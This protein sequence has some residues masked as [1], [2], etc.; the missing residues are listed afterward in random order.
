LSDTSRDSGF[1]L[2]EV[3]IAVVLLGILSAALYGSYFGVLRARDRASSGMESRRELGATLD[4]IRREVSSAQFRQSDKRLRFVVEDRD[5]FGTPSS[6]LTLT[7]E[8]PT[9]GQNRK[10]SGIITVAYRITEKNKKRTLTRQERDL[11][12]EEELILAYPQMEQITAFLVECYDGS[13]W[14]KS[15]DSAINN[16]LPNRVRVTVQIE[17]EGKTVEFSMLSAPRVS[18]I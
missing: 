1:T 6:T 3:L 8:V 5:S 7:T 18:G 4:L 10:E 16:R 17:D 11:F 2:L 9:A 14:V 15:W 13:K 12:S